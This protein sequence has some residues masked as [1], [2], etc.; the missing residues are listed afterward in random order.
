ML[1]LI[2]FDLDGTLID[3]AR[4]LANATNQLIEESGASPLPVEVITSM[5]GDGAAVL[6]R[7]AMAAASLDVDPS[8]ALARFLEIYDTCLLAHTRPYPGIE[9]V[10][11]TL[12]GTFRLAVLTNKPSSATR[13]ILEGLNLLRWFQDVVGGDSLVPRKPDPAALLDLVS[14]AGAT[15]GTTLL[16]GD[17]P[18]DLQTGRRAG[19]AICLARYGFGFRFDGTDFA[20]TEHFIDE[21]VAL[22]PLVRQLAGTEFGSAES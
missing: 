10:L 3:S 8:L 18:V 9:E 15:P 21:P 16:V 14:S 6:V 19:T 22:L 5:V 17:S 2:V 1:R 13:K 12:S 11:T 7:R 4:D 20:S